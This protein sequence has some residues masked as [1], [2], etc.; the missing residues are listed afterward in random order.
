[1][2]I[3]TPLRYFT[4]IFYVKRFRNSSTTTQVATEPLTPFS[5]YSQFLMDMKLYD[6]RKYGTQT[7]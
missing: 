2:L 3:C 5:E 6:I 1:M 7:A 4:Q